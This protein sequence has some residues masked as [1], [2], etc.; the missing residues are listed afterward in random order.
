VIVVYDNDL[1]DPHPN[2]TAQWMMTIIFPVVLFMILVIA[3]IEIPGMVYYGFEYWGFLG[4]RIRGAAQMNKILTTVT[5][6]LYI[7]LCF[8]KLFQYR[9]NQQ[10]SSSTDTNTFYTNSTTIAP[11]SYDPVTTNQWYD[12]VKQCEVILVIVVWINMYY[13]FMGFEKSG[14]RATLQYIVII[15]YVHIFC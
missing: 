3:L 12:N 7:T 5:I 6:I 2:H 4:K 1:P 15:L 14:K 9:E 10:N 13:F 11:T 8:Y